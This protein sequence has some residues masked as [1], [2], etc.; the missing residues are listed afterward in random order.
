VTSPDGSTDTRTTAGRDIV[1]G[2]SR[3]T[4]TVRVWHGELGW[5]VLD[6]LETPGGC[7]A[8]WSNIDKTQ[9]RVREAGEIVEFNWEQRSQDGYQFLAPDIQ[10]LER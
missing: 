10:Q 1:V 5:G 6:S 7:W 8:H 4:G 9:L 3:T 2:M